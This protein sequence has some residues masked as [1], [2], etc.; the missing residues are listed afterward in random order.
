MSAHSRGTGRPPPGNEAARQ[1]G[2]A[3]ARPK[4]SISSRASKIVASAGRR[5][6]GIAVSRPSDKAIKAAMRFLA[7]WGAR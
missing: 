4:T 7:P 1:P 6:R 3:G 2:S 5:K